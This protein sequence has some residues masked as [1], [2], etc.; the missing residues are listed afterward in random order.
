MES[1]LTKKEKKQVTDH[2]HPFSPHRFQGLYCISV[3]C[4]D[5]AEAQFTAALQVS[6]SLP[7]FYP[8]F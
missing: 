1:E 6:L 3:N 2:S 8:H 4:M 7:F 5:N